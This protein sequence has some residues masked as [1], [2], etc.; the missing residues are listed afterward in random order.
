MYMCYVPKQLLLFKIAYEP[1]FFVKKRR[2]DIVYDKAFCVLKTNDIFLAYQG[3]CCCHL[4]LTYINIDQKLSF[5]E[6]AAS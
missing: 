3:D 1:S 5:L 6:M 2:R 4:F